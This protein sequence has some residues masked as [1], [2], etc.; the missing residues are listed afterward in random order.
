[1]MCDKDIIQHFFED[2]KYNMPILKISYLHLCSVTVSST[3]RRS[4]SAGC[5]LSNK[6]PLDILTLEEENDWLS[7]Y[8]KKEL[9]LYAV[10]NARRQQVSKHVQFQCLSIRRMPNS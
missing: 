1:M 8:V 2:L 3:K 10:Y 5:L 9:P 6:F 7:Q 4:L